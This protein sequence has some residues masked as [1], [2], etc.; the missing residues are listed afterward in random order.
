M[1]Q[2]VEMGGYVCVS[3]EH[4]NALLFF[5]L[6]NDQFTLLPY[7]NVGSQP[8]RLCFTADGAALLVATGAGLK[9]LVLNTS[10]GVFQL[11]ATA[12]ADAEQSSSSAAFA[13][14]VTRQVGECAGLTQS[15]DAEE[16]SN[17]YFTDL[18]KPGKRN[19]PVE[20]ITPEATINFKP[21]AKLIKREADRLQEQTNGNEMEE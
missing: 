5:R 13:H 20:L 14:A 8:Q 2:A 4:C 16:K 1:S 3:V 6:N 17:T 7:V 19:R 9:T 10:T 11:G 12:T 18:L 15:A 21:P